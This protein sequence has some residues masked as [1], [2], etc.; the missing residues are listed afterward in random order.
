M[1]D[2]AVGAITQAELH[3]MLAPPESVH[4]PKPQP[5]PPPSPA[6]IAVRR[7][8]PKVSGMPNVA[9]TGRMQETLPVA[10]M[11]AAAAIHAGWPLTCAP[12]ITPS[13]SCDSH[14]RS[15]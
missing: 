10:L 15:P 1:F 9:R 3:G 14:G 4:G 2:C 12:T 6:D 8:G 11:S 13:T 7:S 5:P